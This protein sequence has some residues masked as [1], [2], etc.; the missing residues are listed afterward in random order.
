MASGTD[1]G[2][3]ACRAKVVDGADNWIPAGGRRGWRDGSSSDG[4]AVVVAWRD[5]GD[6]GCCAKSGGALG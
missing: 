5:G 3:V 4:G 6:G 2:W 1:G